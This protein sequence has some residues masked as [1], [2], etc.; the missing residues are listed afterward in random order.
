MSKPLVDV[1]AN[2]R[3]PGFRAIKDSSKIPSPP[4]FQRS[5]RTGGRSPFSVSTTG[6]PCY[7]VMPQATEVVV[8]PTPTSRLPRKSTPTQSA[9]SKSYTYGTG[10]ETPRS[11]LSRSRAGLKQSA[12]AV[13]L[14]SDFDKM[15]PSM[16]RNKPLPSPPIAQLVN[17]QSPPKAQ[18]TLVDAEAGS[19]TEDEWPI[20]QPENISLLKA[21]ALSASD[22]LQQRV[23]SEESVLRRNSIPMLKSRVTTPSSVEN[24]TPSQKSSQ[25]TAEDD[26][27]HKIFR[28]MTEPRTFGLTNP[29]VNSFHAFSTNTEVAIRSPLACKRRTPPS[30]LIPP[31]ISSKRGSLPI[32]G[33]THNE[34]PIP[35]VSDPSRLVKSCSTKC[36]VLETAAGLPLSGQLPTEELE[37]DK[38]QRSLGTKHGELAF[39]GTTPATESHYG[40]IDSISMW[41]LAAGSSLDDEPE[42]YYEGSVRV[43]RLSTNP[44]SG[45]IL[46][47]SAE[48]DAV[49]LG[50]DDSMPAVPALPE[51]VP[52][53]T[54]QE[55]SLGTLARH[56]CNQDLVKVIPSTGSRSLTPS[57]GE[58]EGNES[59]P[60]KITPIRS[61]QPPRNPSNGD[62]SKMS[63][64]PAGLVPIEIGQDEQ[65][66]DSSPDNSCDS[67][68]VSQETPLS[69]AKAKSKDQ[70]PNEVQKH[71]YVGRMHHLHVPELN[72]AQEAGNYSTTLQVEIP[73]RAMQVMGTDGGL[74]KSSARKRLPM[75]WM[76]PKG[77]AST[78]KKDNVGRI[79]PRLGATVG[80]P[81]ANDC[82]E[83]VRYSEQNVADAALKIKAKRSF[84]D[85]FHRR[86]PKPTSQPA[87]KLDSTR[88][89]IVGSVLTQRIRT[90]T[91]CPKGSLARSDAVNAEAKHSITT[92]LSNDAVGTESNRQAALA[93]LDPSLPDISSRPAP[94]AQYDTATVVHK[95]LDH[96]TSMGADSPDRLRGLEIAEAVL[97]A[98]EC[99]QEASM[100][101][102]LARKH[103]CDAEL[104]A[105]R[106]G[107]ELKRLV[108][109]CEHGFD[110]ETLRAM[111]QLIT[112]SG[113]A[114]LSVSAEE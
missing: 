40:S 95:I 102:E 38:Q 46:R 87:K 5:S 63:T 76:M 11:S 26:S 9:F 30:V 94:V 55:R 43:R 62:F 104:S 64:S 92:S 80:S 90:S 54:S 6:S 91:N 10:H 52:E 73:Q 71:S 53:K 113:V 112:A 50:R 69:Q 29:C 109:L 49:L 27:S 21:P 34:V 16:G 86:D 32:S 96:V 20:L 1:D 14:S 24:R 97:H 48:A 106:A 51:H 7:T 13:P 23:V 88:S 15:S 110:S 67:F 105:E 114:R 39:P 82:S 58:M 4:Q 98:V 56:V 3:Q 18:R 41:S 85:I 108:K 61:M 35:H 99:S 47:I 42:A 70:I 100:S 79:P 107:V 101:A 103:A 19:P 22:G 60:V 8:S 68:K 12:I 75:T 83:G 77:A 45:P 2:P 57:S 81:H 89:S 72:S 65:V 59:T 28:Q 66:G 111:K 33:K 74:S 84:R 37:T 31:R 36:P 44:F 78:A 25:S 93:T 17:P